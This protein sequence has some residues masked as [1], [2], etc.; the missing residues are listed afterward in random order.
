MKLETWIHTALH[1]GCVALLVLQG[2]ASC[3][4]KRTGWKI[5]ST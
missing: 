3:S 5:V 2:L 1:I 4:Y